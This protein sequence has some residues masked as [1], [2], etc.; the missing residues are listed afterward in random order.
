MSDPPAESIPCR[1]KSQFLATAVLFPRL[2]A[3]NCERPPTQ[4]PRGIV[5][6]L[7]TAI[8]HLDR[9]AKFITCSLPPARA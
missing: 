9:G 2:L 7:L 5:A 8:R 6:R 3:R 1:S 4:L